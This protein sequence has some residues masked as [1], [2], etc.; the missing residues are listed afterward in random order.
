[1]AHDPA[2]APLARDVRMVENI[3][4]IQPG[5]GLWKTASAV[6]ATF[7]IYVPDP[8]AQ[9][10]GLLAVMQEGDHPIQLGLRLKLVD[11]TP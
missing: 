8:Q 10:V 3:Q 9:Q 7:R 1:V 11:G 5:E 6:P 4:R 2:K